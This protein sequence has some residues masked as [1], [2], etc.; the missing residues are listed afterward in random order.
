MTAVVVVGVAIALNLGILVGGVI[1]ARR[2]L[3]LV[4]AERAARKRR[5]DDPAR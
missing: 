2:Q 4:A 1:W 5:N 3:K